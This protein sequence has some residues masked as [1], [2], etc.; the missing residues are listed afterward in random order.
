M[1][2][3]RLSDY[4]FNA[5]SL[6]GSFNLPVHADPN[7]AMVKLVVVKNQSKSFSV[8][9]LTLF[10]DLLKLPA[11]TQQMILSEFAHLVTIRQIISCVLW[12]GEHLKLHG[13]Q[14]CSCGN[15]NHVYVYV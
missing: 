4:P 7:S 13:R 10:V 12:F 9:P 3:K 2:T 15:E 11:F 1:Q 5:I 14:R 6:H 8:Q